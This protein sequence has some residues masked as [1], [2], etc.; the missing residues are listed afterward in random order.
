MR[1]KEIGAYGYLRRLCSASAL[2]AGLAMATSVSA[3]VA[4]VPVD[5]DAI[6]GNPQ[7]VSQLT[8]FNTTVAY[9]ALWGTG[10]GL[11]AR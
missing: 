7:A 4:Q 8:P 9:V 6:A 5:P 2:T 11:L 1:I 10:L 3:G